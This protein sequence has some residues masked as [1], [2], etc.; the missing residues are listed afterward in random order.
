MIQS[1]HLST[2]LDEINSQN[3]GTRK[4]SFLIISLLT[5]VPSVSDGIL[6]LAK[7]P[8]VNG[9]I[10]LG[11]SQ[12]RLLDANT[13]QFYHQKRDVINRK[14]GGDNRYIC[15]QIRHENNGLR[16]KMMS[17]SD[18]VGKSQTDTL[19]GC[20]DPD[21]VLCGGFYLF[22]KSRV[23][24]TDSSSHGKLDGESTGELQPKPQKTAANFFQQKAK[25]PNFSA[26]IG[27]IFE[28]K[29]NSLHSVF[30]KTI[31]KNQESTLIRHF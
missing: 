28:R 27:E 22:G 7:I 17:V 10:G 8:K 24:T 5:R 26:K 16:F 3:E 13:L 15:W 11:T 12:K 9:L 29:K 6:R 1:V 4:I 30:V 18:F 25:N 19:S 14:T 21:S 23:V 31:G 2:F 20:P